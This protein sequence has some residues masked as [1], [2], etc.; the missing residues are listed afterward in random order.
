MVVVCGTLEGKNRL[1]YRGMMLNSMQDELKRIYLNYENHE[2]KKL[3]EQC[4]A[5][6]NTIYYPNCYSN[7]CN[8]CKGFS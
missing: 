6:R 3:Q 7:S 1:V 2:R 5:F 8:Y 4:V